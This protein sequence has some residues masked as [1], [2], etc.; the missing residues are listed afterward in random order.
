MDRDER[1]L[2]PLDP[3]MNPTQWNRMVGNIMFAATDEL[4]RRLIIQS[5]LLLVAGW[6]RPALGG[7]A[8][9]AAV[10]SALLLLFRGGPNEQI[11][12]VRAVAEGIGLPNS[13]DAWLS[14]GDT[15]AL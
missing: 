9:V 12:E 6:F 7:S 11:A 2:R 1:D 10:G 15:D 13:I 8:L 3:Q 5:P 4:E 14:T